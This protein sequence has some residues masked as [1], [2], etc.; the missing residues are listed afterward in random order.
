MTT[1]YFFL[2]ILLIFL[3]MVSIFFS[4]SETGLMSLNRYRLRHLARKNDVGAQRI[5]N[6]LSRLDRLLGV[7][8]I[9]NTVSNI[10]AAAVV[11]VL[12][13]HFF[14]DFGVAIGTLCFTFFILIFGEIAPKTMAALH[15]ESIAWPTSII[16]KFLLKIMYPIVWLANGVANGFLKL[17][18]ANL[19]HGRMEGLTLEEL[20]SLL[21]ENKNKVSS[22]YHE[23]L[24]RILDMEQVTVEDIMVPRNEIFGIDLN[25]DW[26]QILSELISCPY[27]T[28]P[29]YKED[30]NHILGTL[31]L[32]KLL[33]VL[34]QKKLNKEELVALVDEPYFIPKDATANQQ[35]LNFKDQKQ[36]FGLV[37]DEYG[38]IQGLITLQNILEEIVG[39]F[40]KD[41]KLTHL[42]LP[43]PDKSYI[44]DASIDL[45]SL[46]E[47]TDWKLPTG[48]P[49]TLSGLVIEHLEMIPSSGVCTRIGGYPMEIV[50]V[51]HNII[52]LIRIFPQLYREPKE[53]INLT[54]SR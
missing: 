4:A 9:G 47:I 48:G 25:Q 49:R 52:K 31:D 2:I 10:F 39:E 54:D 7:I 8:L 45:R 21:D 51:S 32:H 28:I 17:F 50:R 24:L 53:K 35:L 36:V 43:Q 15:P 26:Q 1:G 12:S 30:I 6:L 3:I 11:T 18:G 19:E 38:D 46:N 42:I 22:N 33:I 29:L 13:A 44:V 34:Q 37:V 16:L 27:S 5:L 41:V 23:M 40:T 14:G 20:R